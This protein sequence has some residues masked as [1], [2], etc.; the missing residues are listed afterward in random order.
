MELFYECSDGTKINFLGDSVFAPAPETLLSTKWEYKSAGQKSRIRNFYKNVQTAPLALEIMCDSEEEFNQKMN[1]MHRCFDTD[2]K[3]MKPGKIWW[4]DWYKEA[5]V[6]VSDNSSWEYMYDAIDKNLTFMFQNPF[7]IKTKTESIKP[8]QGSTGAEVDFPFDMNLDLPYHEQ[9]NIF[10]CDAIY[11]CDFVM[12][13]Y[14]PAYYPVLL[15]NEKSYA[16]NTYVQ[17]GQ[18]AVIDSKNKTISLISIDGTKENILDSRDTSSYIFEKIKRGYFKVNRSSDFGV[19]LE[20][21]YERG[22]PEWT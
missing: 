7:W 19:D 15:I 1:E 6:T 10:M 11:D 4:N 22:E 3:S 8:S 18:K 17:D 16:L 12:T 21:M 14:G 5:Y 13:I 2:I 9:T 20:M